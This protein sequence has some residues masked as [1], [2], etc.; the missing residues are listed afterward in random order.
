MNWLGF[1]LL[2]VDKYDHALAVFHQ[3]IAE[4]PT[5]SEAEES[6]AE[7]YLQQGD[8]ANAIAAFQKAFDL[9]LKNEDARK[10]LARLRSQ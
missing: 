10:K 8:K 7:A 4:N 1:E 3:V 5:S 2:K 6:L 9:G